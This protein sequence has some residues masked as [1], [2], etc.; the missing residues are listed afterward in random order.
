MSTSELPWDW[1][2]TIY[3]SFEEARQTVIDAGE[4]IADDRQKDKVKAVL[5]VVV[6][7]SGK[8]IFDRAQQLLLD[9][10]RNMLCLFE[11]PHVRRVITDNYQAS[12][13]DWEDTKSFRHPLIWQVSAQES[14]KGVLA[15]VDYDAKLETAIVIEYPA[16]L[17]F[18]SKPGHRLFSTSWHTISSKVSQFHLPHSR[19][20]ANSTK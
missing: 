8:R 13:D 20:G 7:G 5:D 18:P 4:V 19:I 10:H 12:I 6:G 3:S 17:T 16:L 14:W 11:A 15:E 9:F 1:R 2:N